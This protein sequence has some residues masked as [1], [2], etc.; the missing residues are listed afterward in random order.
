MPFFVA[1]ILTYIHLLIQKSSLLST[2]TLAGPKVQTHALGFRT[3][4]GS[5]VV[6]DLGVVCFQWALA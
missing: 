3:K 5:V 1:E 4:T 2:L 6:F